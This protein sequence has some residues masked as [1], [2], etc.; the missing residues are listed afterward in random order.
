MTIKELST[1]FHGNVIVE[2]TVHTGKNSIRFDELYDGKLAKLT[3]EN[4]LSLSIKVI[5][6]IPG[7]TI[8]N[9]IPFLHIYV[10]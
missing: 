10:D 9:G 7:S 1:V 8:R 2:R 6:N 3:D 5:E 4:I